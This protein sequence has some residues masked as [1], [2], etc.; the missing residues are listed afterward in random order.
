MC[1]Y[2]TA[3]RRTVV[4]QIALVEA[5]LSTAGSHAALHTHLLHWVVLT[6]FARSKGLLGAFGTSQIL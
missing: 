1:L 3:G 2:K 6:V 5:R 4:S